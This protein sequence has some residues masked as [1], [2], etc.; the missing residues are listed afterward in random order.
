VEEFSNIYFS[1]EARKLYSESETIVAELV[2]ENETA[3]LRI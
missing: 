1:G 2:N 3:P